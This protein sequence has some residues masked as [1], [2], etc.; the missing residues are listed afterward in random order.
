MVAELGGRD[1]KRKL[2]V[3]RVLGKG[4]E[5]L[6]REVKEPLHLVLERFVSLDPL[7]LH[8]L[9]L[10]CVKHVVHHRGGRDQFVVSS[11][12]LRLLLVISNESLRLLLVIMVGG[13]NVVIVIS[14]HDW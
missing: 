5:Q 8:L 6:F 12:R 2:R 14:H 13:F 9:H 7:L 3:L 11:E 1:V 10:L 4:D